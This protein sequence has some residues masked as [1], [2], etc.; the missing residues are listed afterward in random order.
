LGRGGPKDESAAKTYYA[1][2]AALGNE[3]AK[4]AL[5]RIE[6]PYVLKDKRGNVMT[7]LCF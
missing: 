7:N 4:A 3:D 1:R 2:A 6:C 5:K